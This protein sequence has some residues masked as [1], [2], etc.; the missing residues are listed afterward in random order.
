MQTEYW[1]ARLENEGQMRDQIDQRP[2]DT[3]GKWRTKFPEY[4]NAEPENAGTISHRDLNWRN[5]KLLSIVVLQLC[6]LTLECIDYFSTAVVQ[7][8]VAMFQRLTDTL[9]IEV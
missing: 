5:A 3:T 8:V 7:L 1:S 4:G 9:L 6:Y 2:T